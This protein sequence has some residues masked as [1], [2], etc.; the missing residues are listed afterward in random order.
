LIKDRRFLQVMKI[1]ILYED[2]DILVIDKPSGILVHP[3][4]KSKEKTILDIFR[5]KYPKLQIVHRLD[6][7]TSGVLIWRRTRKRTSF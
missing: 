3:D 4:E 6:R 7:D 2:K 1:K 5:K